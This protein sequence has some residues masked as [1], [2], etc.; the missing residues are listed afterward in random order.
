MNLDLFKNTMSQK[1]GRTGLQLQKYSPQ[2]LLGLGL[3]GGVIAAVMASKAT[4]EGAGEILDIA[5][6][7]LDILETEE[8]RQR[9]RN[10]G[11]VSKKEITKD[12]ANL[13]VKTGL[14]FAKLYG[15]SVGLGVLSISAILGAHGIMAKR[16]VA[17]SAAYAL[18]AE[19]YKNYRERVVQELG[20]E[21]DQEFHLGLRETDEESYIHVNNDGTT[22][23]RTK[24]V[25]K[26]FIPDGHG[27]SIYARCFDNTNKQWQSDRNL[28]RAF[29][30]AQQN[31]L[32]DKLIITGHV[33]LNEVYERLGFDVTPEGQLVGWVLRSPEQMKKEGRDG[34][35]SLGLDNPATQA[36]WEFMRGMNDAIWIDPN[37]D[38][39]VYD[40]I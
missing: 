33:F 18:L 1:F 19:G 22:E 31:Y 27:L 12:R 30:I 25:E 14:K 10:G 20:E 11:W 29:L 3:V 9:G 6:E 17:L 34:Y 16:Q 5:K 32:N 8:A 35:I 40:L 37:V 24:K 2:I 28:N 38:G 7:E 36:D 13:Y 21:K 23:V 4:L 39:V 26:K 15:P